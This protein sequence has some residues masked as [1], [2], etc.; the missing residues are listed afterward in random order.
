MQWMA[1]EAK[2]KMK[3][4]TDRVKQTL[5]LLATLKAPDNL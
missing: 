4:V 3:A 2:N 1:S 5:K